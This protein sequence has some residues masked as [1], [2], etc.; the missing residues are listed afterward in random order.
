MPSFLKFAD[1]LQNEKD[2]TSIQKEA[3]HS[4]LFQSYQDIYVNAA[5]LSFKIKGISLEKA[6]QIIKN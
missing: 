4:V 2:L 1:F 6:Y 5:D 3:L